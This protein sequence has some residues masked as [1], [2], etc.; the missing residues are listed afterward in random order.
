[1]WQGSAGA[2]FAIRWRPWPNVNTNTD[3][4]QFSIA[5]L[6]GTNVFSSED[7]NTKHPLLATST[8][9]N[10]LGGELDSKQSYLARLRFERRVRTESLSYPGA[11]GTAAL[12]SELAFYVSTLSTNY[13]TNFTSA[14]TLTNGLVQIGVSANS[15]TPLQVR[16]PYTLFE[17]HDFVNWSIT[18]VEALSVPYFRIPPPT[19][20]TFYKAAILP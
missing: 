1:L 11:R 9:V 8:N 17:T 15:T 19:E 6:N 3:T 12:F 13:M 7:P 5:K 10:V 2:G 4:I 20:P 16:R 14:V 18:K